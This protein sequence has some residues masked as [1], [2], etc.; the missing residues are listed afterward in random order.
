LSSFAILLSF[1]ILSIDRSDLWCRLRE[2]KHRTSETAGAVETPA[3]NS[4][5]LF[6]SLRHGGLGG[7]TAASAKVRIPLPEPRTPL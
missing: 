3:A 6:S 4:W 7:R 2:T 5:V 1:A